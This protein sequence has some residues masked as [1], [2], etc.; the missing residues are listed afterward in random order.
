MD[1]QLEQKSADPNLVNLSASSLK[2]TFQLAYKLLTKIVQITGWEQLLKYRSKIFVMEDEYQGSTSSIDEAE[3]RGNDISK[4]RSKRL[5]ER[6]LDNL[7]MLLYEDEN[8]HRLAI[9]A[10]YFDAQNSKYHKLTV[11]WEL[12]GLCGKDWD[13]FQ[14]LR[15]L[16][17]LGFPKIFSSMRKESITVYID[18]HKRIRRDSVSQ[19]PS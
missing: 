7:F 3:V 19:T 4:M 15:R 6:W 18:E 5:C 14:K 11:E 16:S 1:V 17:K 9:R 10:L 8:L 12:F 2:S 13:I